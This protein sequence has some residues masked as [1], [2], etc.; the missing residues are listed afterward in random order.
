VLA[1]VVNERRVHPLLLV[2][3]AIFVWYFVHGAVG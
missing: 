2:F 1:T 3:T